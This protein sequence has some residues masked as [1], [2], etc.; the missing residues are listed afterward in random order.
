[1][2]R[3]RHLSGS[4]CVA[5]TWRKQQNRPYLLKGPGHKLGNSRLDV[6]DPPLT[7]PHFSMLGPT[8]PEFPSA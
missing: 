7:P 4:P 8:C 6:P 2:Q 5:G 1:M 3:V